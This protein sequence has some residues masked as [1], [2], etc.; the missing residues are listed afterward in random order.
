MNGNGKNGKKFLISTRPLPFRQ[1]RGTAE[2][3]IQTV[4][5]PY[6]HASE[7][8][9]CA[10]VRKIHVNNGQDTKNGAGAD[11]VVLWRQLSFGAE[12]EIAKT[13]I[14]LQNLDMETCDTHEIAAV[15]VCFEVQP[16]YEQP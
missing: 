11:Y 14:Q 16:L 3:R 4:T 5:Q 10:G 12:D 2:H 6:L 13:G 1:M 15:A 8:I 9:A 7:P